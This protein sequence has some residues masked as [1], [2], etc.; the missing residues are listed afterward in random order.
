[1]R[2]I[3]TYSVDCNWPYFKT[4]SLYNK[5]TFLL[6]AFI[7][8]KRK[9]VYCSQAVFEFLLPVEALFLNL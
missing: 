9:T 7:S 2:G 4:C 3:Y 8:K 6:L 1:M 5:F